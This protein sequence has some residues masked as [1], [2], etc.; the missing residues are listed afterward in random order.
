MQ[1]ARTLRPG[2]IKAEMGVG[3][4]VPVT[5][6]INLTAQAID[7]AGEG[8]SAASEERKFDF[9]EKRQDDLI[10]TSLA[11]ASLPPS[12]SYQYG[13][14]VGIFE[15]FEL[16]G[17]YAI[18]SIRIDA[19]YRFVH[20]GQSEQS[21]FDNIDDGE[22][23]R[24]FDVA[25]GFATS[26]YIFSNVVVAA[27]QTFGMGNF[28]RWDFEVPLYISFDVNRYFGIYAAPKYV[29]S[30]TRFDEKLRKFANSCDCEFID[31]T[32]PGEVNMHF[33]G[34]TFGLRLGWPRFSVF[35]E[36]TGGNMFAR[37]YILGKTR[38]LGGFTLY[39]SI[40]FAITLH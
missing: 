26:K 14:R 28:D 18:N 25:I 37:T 32:I 23:R 12:Y 31:T 15:N 10:T 35:A 38:E 33:V 27:L 4:Y 20:V 7:L 21:W 19:K 2:Q 30:N 39:P 17:R 22:T 8:I 16:G 5:Q 24:S 1:T 40:G 34:S 29:F 3:V 13:M 6:S 9:N 36:V 11:L